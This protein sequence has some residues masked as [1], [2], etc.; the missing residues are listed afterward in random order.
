MESDAQVQVPY[1]RVGGVSGPHV[2][3]FQGPACMEDTGIQVVYD[4]HTSI[5]CWT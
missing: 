1:Q 5:C 2:C 4:Q 3:D